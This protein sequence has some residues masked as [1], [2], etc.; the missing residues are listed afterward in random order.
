MVVDRAIALDLRLKAEKA[1][2][3]L[4]DVDVLVEVRR[5]RPF[6]RTRKRMAR[7]VLEF[8]VRGLKQLLS[9]LDRH[10]D[11]DPVLGRRVVNVLDVVLLEPLVDKTDTLILWL[12]NVRYLGRRQVLTV[13]LVLRV[14]DFNQ[15]TL[16]ETFV[17]LLDTDLEIDRLGFVGWSDCSP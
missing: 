7:G 16:D 11:R 8:G 14:R 12:D 2:R 13:A 10:D 3:G 4:D 6:W 1:G 5:E 15:M 17:A 9:L